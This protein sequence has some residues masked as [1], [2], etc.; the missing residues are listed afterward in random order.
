[1]GP[2]WGRQDP[3]WPRVGPIN[4][5]VMGIIFLQ[6]L[7][8]CFLMPWAWKGKKDRQESE[9][10]LQNEAYFIASNAGYRNYPIPFSYWM[11]SIKSLCE[12]S[13]AKNFEPIHSKIG[14][15]RGVKIDDVELWRS[16]T[17]HRP[18]DMRRYFEWQYCPMI[19]TCEQYLY[20][21]TYI[22]I[23]I[24]FLRNDQS[25]FYFARCFKGS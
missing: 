6:W 3:G 18:H 15:L 4:L 13:K 21:H 17:G 16:E 20:T 2:I 9:R 12:I 25:Y 1:M 19:H 5:A 11:T 10:W 14:I 8:R 22:Y 23:H 7:L 24:S